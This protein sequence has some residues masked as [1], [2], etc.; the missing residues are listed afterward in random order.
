MGREALSP[1]HFPIDK[2]KSVS[3]NKNSDG[4]VNNDGKS[5]SCLRFGALACAI[6]YEIA[7]AIEPAFSKSAPFPS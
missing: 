7:A 2:S 4:D 3:S 5:E 1:Y 6:R